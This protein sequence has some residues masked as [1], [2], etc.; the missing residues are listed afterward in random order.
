MQGQVA[1]RVALLAAALLA[2][3]GRGGQAPASPGCP[4]GAVGEPPVAAARG[5]CVCPCP[6]AAGE[7]RSDAGPPPAAED[8][9]E[10]VAA[11]HR[12]M[13]HSDGEGCLAELSAVGQ[14]D[15]RLLGRLAVTHGQC[16][17]LAG[18]CQAGKERVAAWYVAEAAMGRERAAELAEQLA[19]LRCRGGDATER[20]ELLG[21]LQGLSDGAY[22]EARSA[23]HCRERLIAIERLA[24]RVAPRGPD[25]TRLTGGLQA[26]FHTAAACYVR[27]GDCASAREAYRRHYPKG[28]LEALPDEAQRE[29]VVRDSFAS[30]F[31]RC[32]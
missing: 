2:A 5:A 17:M 21:A 29:R 27:A 20:D 28:A 26:L 11:A 25:D 16:E 9:G 32:R 19:A 18:R 13:M 31:E 7:G 8:L 12:K 22:L 3:C 10:R 30:S 15:P 14:R 24:P 4:S 6:C 23:A 1:P